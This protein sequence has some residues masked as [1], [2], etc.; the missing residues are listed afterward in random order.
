MGLAREIKRLRI[1][2]GLEQS[3]SVGLEGFRLSV[4]R[5]CINSGIRH[6]QDEQNQFFNS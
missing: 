2:K 1:I 5:C 4:G 3:Q 6:F